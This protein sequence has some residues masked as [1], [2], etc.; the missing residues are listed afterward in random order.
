MVWWRLRSSP[1]TSEARENDNN[2]DHDRNNGKNNK[3]DNSGHVND[4]TGDGTDAIV[5]ITMMVKIVNMQ[6]I[7]LVGS[8]L[9]NNPVGHPPPTSSKVC[10]TSFAQNPVRGV[11]PPPPQ[12][13]AKP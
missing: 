8:V 5:I 4:D 2:D 13:C 12:K 3:D 1:T 7:I 10:I 11:P 9:D 6:I